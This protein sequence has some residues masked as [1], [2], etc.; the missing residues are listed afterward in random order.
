MY[1]HTNAREPYEIRADAESRT[2]TGRG[3]H[4]R[5]ED[6]KNGE[7]GRRGER[8]DDNLLNIELLLGDGESSNRNHDTLHY[9]L[10]STLEK[11]AKIDTGHVFIYYSTIKKSCN[12]YILFKTLK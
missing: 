8:D 5:N 6:I 4:R 11:F 2:A 7:G 10:N 12:I 9:V 1:L 3:R